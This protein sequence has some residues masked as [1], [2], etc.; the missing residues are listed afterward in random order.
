MAQS[1]PINYQLQLQVRA[2]TGG[3]AY[4]LPDGSTFNSVSPSLN[5]AGNVAV[6][7]NTVGATTSP[8]LW[9]G[10]HGIGSL[11][12][13]A[14]D[15]A[16][17]L[18][19]GYLNNN[20]QV[21]F[22]RAASTTASDDGLY[23]YDNAI[24]LTTRVTNGPLGA[25]SYTNP[26]INDNG[27][28][29]MRVKFSTPQALF[30][31]N[32]SSNTFTNYVTETS[33]DPGSPYS[34]LYAPAFNNNNKIAAQ[35][36]LT[37]QAATYK[38]LRVW[39]PDGTSVLVASGDSSAGPVFFAFD[40]SISMNNNDQVAFTTRTSTSS[41]TRRI[42]V[43]NGVTT[44]IFPTVSAGAGFT[45]ID[46]F[47]PSINDSGLVAFRGNDNQPT[48]RDSVFV[49][50]GTTFQRIAGVNDTLMTD[51]GPRVVGFLM[52]AV[53]INNSGSV[54]FG[55]QFTA[56][57]GG[58]NAIYVAYASIVSDGGKS[59]VSAGPNGVLD[60]GEVVTVSLGARNSGEP[61][62]GC[63]TAALTGTL[64]TSGGVTSPSGSQN[65][66]ALCPSSPAVFRDFTFTVD[67]ALPCGSTVTASLR[68]MDG[69]TDYGTLTYTFTTGSLS[70]VLAENFDGVVAP[71]LPP[72]WSGTWVTSTTA[73]YS[74]P[75]AAFAPDPSTIAINELGTSFTVPAG[76]ARLSF[77]NSFN[78][79][80][81]HDGVVM[82]I[83]I[84]AGAFM[85]ILSAGGT[86]VTGGYTGTL[87][88]AFSNPFPGRQAWT[89]NSG[90]YI[91]SVINLPAAANGQLVQ[92]KWRMGSDNGVGGVGVMID[93]VLITSPVCGGSA[94]AVNAAV[95][96]KVHGGAGTFDISLPLVPLAGAVGIECRAGG[97]SGE[98]KLV[99]TFANPV[100]V[101]TAAVTT[102]I[103]S[104]ASASVTGAVVTINL[105]GVTNAQRLGVTL[106]NVSDGAN[107]GSVMIPMGVL[108]A[109]TN[110]N[111]SVSASDIG[112]TKGQ[113]GQATMGTNF[114]TDVNVNGSI[115]AA[116]I[117]L[118]KSKSGTSLP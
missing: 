56:G 114:R 51:T 31:Y 63:T 24:G 6:K 82:E 70:T 111:G 32:V 104:V 74:P 64:Q 97:L 118:V 37:A 102:G 45:S 7:V 53:R 65:Y 72:G 62:T 14:N 39:S 16:A 41:T 117:G 10:G 18:S 84:G 8:G 71:A 108:E 109:D 3:T 38:E 105:S 20:D 40:N 15:D 35:A 87:S 25:T 49:T 100:T 34:F 81:A 23:V 98:N 30:S 85:D 59:I 103:G 78:T 110:G 1:F 76:G 80:S 47:A 21:S 9:F 26:Q 33:G 52:G 75:N 4:N 61:G 54:A 77:K 83:K 58:G 115:S 73:P 113:S 43:S 48:T 116:D 55:V 42:V 88:T 99:V 95:S 13:N 29:G 57:S 11:V 28:I 22:P 68:M 101:G 19:D 94:P 27:I 93:D 17:I 44:T 60:P 89:G 86:F 46:S 5:D 66:G 92:L 91:D 67:P 106:S 79:E 107:L 96:S 36:N 69:T 12:H 50:D 2:N 90:G 112:Q